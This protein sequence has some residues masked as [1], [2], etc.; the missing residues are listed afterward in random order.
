MI[1]YLAKFLACMTAI[2]VI[3]KTT[4]DFK[5]KKE[6]FVMF[7]F[8]YSVWWGVVILTLFPQLVDKVFGSGRSGV[9]TFMGLVIVFVLYLSYRLYIKADRTEKSLHRVIKELA[10]SLPK[11]KE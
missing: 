2:F 6:S 8:W 9:N 10:I 4:H 1:L 3:A 5:K 7:V 11:E